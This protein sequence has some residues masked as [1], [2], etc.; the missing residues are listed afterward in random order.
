MLRT[1]YEMASRVRRNQSGCDGAASINAPYGSR[2]KL[3]PD[4]LALDGETFVAC[5]TQV[6]SVAS[7]ALIYSPGGLDWHIP[8]ASYA[9]GRGSLRLWF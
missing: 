4:K 3:S 7:D 8:P 9:A 6:H 1:V 2:D 5:I